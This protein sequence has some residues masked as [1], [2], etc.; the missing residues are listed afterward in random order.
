MQAGRFVTIE[1]PDGSGKTSVLARM[2][3]I[4]SQEGYDILTTREPGG[5]PIA[6]QIRELILAVENIAMDSRT[7]ALLFAAQRRQHLVEKVIPNLEAGKLVISDRFVHSSLA[8]QGLARDIPVEEVWQ[9][10]LFAIQDYRPDLTLLI[11]VPAKVGLERIYAARGQR[12]FDRLDREDLAFHNR[13]RQAFLDFAKQDDRIVVVD[14]QAP[15]Q[16]VA[17]EC[18]MIL[19]DRQIIRE[20]E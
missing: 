12:Q 5:S 15:I 17:Q 2:D 1:G 13:V 20:K 16:E 18:I 19:K 14:G 3:E 6:E 8:Y 7:E 4:L 9:I 11:D 10:N